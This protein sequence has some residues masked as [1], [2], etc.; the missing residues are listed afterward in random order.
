M[1]QGLEMFG[2]GKFQ[3]PTTEIK[4]PPTAT[5]QS[6]EY[7]KQVNKLS[8]FLQPPK[9]NL[10]KSEY[11]DKLWGEIQ[12]FQLPP[13]ITEELKIN[14]EFFLKIDLENLFQKPDFKQNLRTMFK[15]FDTSLQPDARKG[16]FIIGFNGILTNLGLRK[17][18]ET[19]P[20]PVAPPGVK[21]VGQ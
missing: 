18:I 19:P 21:I 20:P 15:A 7:L 1:D 2:K 17:P 6:N 11:A 10:E 12:S 16:N 13:E 9:K 3:T 5:P 14:R 8:D 4:T